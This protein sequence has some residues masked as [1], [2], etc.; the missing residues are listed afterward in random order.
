M[1][2]L[3]YRAFADELGQIK[4]AGVGRAANAQAVQKL[5]RAFKRPPP[6]GQT[7]KTPEWVKAVGPLKKTSGIP[8]KLLLNPKF[9]PY[10]ERVA[11][12]GKSAPKLFKGG[13]PVRI[14]GVSP[15]RPKLAPR[16][17]AA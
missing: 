14:P 15:P 11:K 12:G 5:I 8:T 9:M 3:A 16:K 4:L 10:F 13:P 17:L 7:L 6:A 1:H 2:P